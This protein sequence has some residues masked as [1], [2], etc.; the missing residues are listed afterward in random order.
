M[1]KNRKWVSEEFEFIPAVD[2][3][4]TG[5]LICLLD[6]LCPKCDVNAPKYEWG[7]YFVD[8]VYAS[9]GLTPKLLHERW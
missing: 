6:I 4:C 7:K 8:D 9:R 5:D 2:P 1:L 3:L